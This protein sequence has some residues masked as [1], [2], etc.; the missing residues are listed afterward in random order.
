MYK[1]I[2]SVLLHCSFSKNK[3]K[4]QN[5]CFLSYCNYA[6]FWFVTLV[7]HGFLIWFPYFLIVF[8]LAHMVIRLAKLGGYM[9]GFWRQRL[10]LYFIWCKQLVLP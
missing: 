6:C 2:V 10:Y 4:A 7:P 5:K 8:T 9:N 1:Y 3:Q